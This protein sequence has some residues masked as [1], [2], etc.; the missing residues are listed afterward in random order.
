LVERGEP[1]VI[2]RAGKPVAK[3]E[4]YSSKPPQRFG[5]L[6]GQFDVPDDI[7]TVFRKDIEEIFYGE[8]PLAVMTGKK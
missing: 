2:A 4:A 6:E 8:S 1:F 3:V 5:F 7:D